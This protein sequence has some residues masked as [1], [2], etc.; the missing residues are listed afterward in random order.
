[1][2]IF[3]HDDVLILDDAFATRIAER[4]RDFDILGFAGTRKLIN[5]YWWGAGLPSI[6]GAMSHALPHCL[7]LNVWNV[8]PWPVVDD[9][10]AIDGLCMAMR[11]EAAEA[12]GFD[13]ETFDGFHLYDLDFSFSAWR[14]G[15][16][17]GV[18]CDI[19]VIHAS[20]GSY[21]AHH[22]HYGRR[23]LEKHRDLLPNPPAQREQIQGRSA[24]FTTSRALVDTWRAA[25]FRR[26]QVCNER[27]RAAA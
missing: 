23:F 2:L 5:D 21:D 9:I 16:K 10:V 14:A 22:A 13:A 15:K 6:S 18:C 17:L 27:D 24:V 26:V 11:R 7:T 3:S 8:E 4:L 20:I 25:V 12:I 19:P 1:M